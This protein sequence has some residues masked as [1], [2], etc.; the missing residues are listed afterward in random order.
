L[1][2]SGESDVTVSE[3]EDQYLV[4]ACQEASAFLALDQGAKAESDWFK[5]IRNDRDA[6]TFFTRDALA[7]TTGFGIIVATLIARAYLA[8]VENSEDELAP[9]GSKVRDLKARENALESELDADCR[10][11]RCGDG[12]AYAGLEKTPQVFDFTGVFHHF[13]RREGDSN[14]R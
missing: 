8:C 10:R 7:K 13:W 3:K 2:K 11:D 9:T 12:S 14:P 4:I 1:T 6:R 5:C